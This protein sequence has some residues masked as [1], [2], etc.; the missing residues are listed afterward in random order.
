MMVRFGEADEC[1]QVSGDGW[2]I[3]LFVIFCILILAFFFL[4]LFLFLKLIEYP[5]VLFSFSTLNKIKM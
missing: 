1:V 3:T 2:L 5:K 4:F